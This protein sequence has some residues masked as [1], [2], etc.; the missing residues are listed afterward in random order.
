MKTSY[1]NKSVAVIAAIASLTVSGHASLFM[2][3]VA[4]DPA[5]GAEK[6][7]TAGMLNSDT[8]PASGSIINWGGSGSIAVDY[9]NRSV[10]L[11]LGATQTIRSIKLRD[12]DGLSR[13]A[14]NA[15][16]TLWHSSDN[17]NYN[18]ITGWTL[19]TN[20]VDGRLV[21]TLRGFNVTS[22]YVK[23]NTTFADTNYT[24]VLE[25]L[26]RDLVASA[27]VVGLLSND[28]NP[29][30]GS[31][32]A[33][34]GTGNAGFDCTNRSV[35]L[36]FGSPRPVRSITLRDSDSIT[37]VAGEDCTLWYSSDN[38]NYN[39]IT[40]WTLGT[41]VVDGRLT[42]TF[43]G[44]DVTSRYVKVNTGFTDSSYTFL[45][46]GLQDN[47]W[48]FSN[49]IPDFGVALHSDGDRLFPPGNLDG[50]VYGVTAGEAVS[51]IIDE[52]DNT[53][54]AGFGTLKMGL[55]TDI[56]NWN[57][58][59]GSP[60]DWRLDD[61]K[62]ALSADGWA[63]YANMRGLAWTARRL[64]T[65]GID[66]VRIAG[67]RAKE[68]GMH[69]ILS[70]RIADTHFTD[71]PAGYPLTSKFYLDSEASTDSNNWVTI[72]HSG[73]SPVPGYS[74]FDELMNFDKAGVR[75]NR[76]A[77]ICEALGRYADII[78]G[79]E[80]EFNRNLA[81]FPLNQGASRTNLVTDFL[82][83]VRGH[84]DTLEAAT[85]RHYSFGIRVPWDQ[86]LCLTQG[87]DVDR[88][89]RDRRVDYIVP[90]QIMTVPHDMDIRSWTAAGRPNSPWD[91]G[92]AVY[93]GLPARKPR[94][95]TFP[96][97]Y[98]VAA[99]YSS[100]LGA[101]NPQLL[102]A[103]CGF[104]AMGADGVE[105]YNFAALAANTAS[106]A[107]KT[108]LGWLATNLAG[109][110]DIGL[111][112]RIFAVTPMNAAG[113]EGRL[114]QIKKLPA[115][116][117]TNGTVWVNS[118]D[119]ALSKLG[120]NRYDSSIFITG[121]GNMAAGEKW[122]LRLGIRNITNQT[123]ILT[124]L[125]LLIT[126][127]GKEMWNGSVYQNLTGAGVTNSPAPTHYITIPVPDSFPLKD[128]DF[129]SITI[130]Q[131]GGSSGFSIQEVQIGIFP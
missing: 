72:K 10:A 44:F 99:N 86:A 11:D 14:T 75:S 39:Q 98:T 95:W 32:A 58:Q 122:L 35:A 38:T 15:D 37:R 123:L 79:F 69:F 87:L 83:A 130:R 92:V 60:R 90:S 4:V 43:M 109:K 1:E 7:R 3:L 131:N 119:G 106:A 22:R 125:N 65:A 107:D 73:S 45:L 104:Y 8:N 52:V 6:V 31:V 108:R 59:A 105:L 57:S 91:R 71:D 127:N 128:S 129:N 55:G 9:R 34:G 121:R 93:A 124:D 5:S 49:M 116:F 2:R 76:L 97:E 63:V 102:G 48:S 68:R 13:I 16:Y 27:T 17:T 56:V 85:N 66:P 117:R 46:Q 51:T 54:N 96:L 80:I 81:L 67:E 64:F 114:E 21:H 33:W 62:W 118:R 88:Q 84:L 28:T 82:Q 115:E 126:L 103:A 23:V 70:Y 101:E 120:T 100:G 42:H 41:N 74:R 36:D 50:P 110:A 61:P 111:F 94:G 24:F 53:A 26:Q 77:V 18:Q 12:S 78:D 20:A 113:Y 25:H 89:I 30:N 47:V 29:A 40:G 19:S 112:E